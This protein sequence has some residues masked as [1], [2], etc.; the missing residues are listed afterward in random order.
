MSITITTANETKMLADLR[1]IAQLLA[2]S[3]D[4]IG[5]YLAQVNQARELAES[6]LPHEADASTPAPVNG[7]DSFARVHLNFGGRVLVLERLDGSRR[8]VVKTKPDDPEDKHW[9]LHATLEQ[10]QELLAHGG[11]IRWKTEKAQGTPFWRNE[12]TFT[13]WGTRRQAD[14][15]LDNEA[16]FVAARLSA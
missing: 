16:A 15:W 6:Y 5:D 3:D 2:E 14:N 13:Y 4:K 1:R 11:M 12:Y 7:W 10:V 8:I 9:T